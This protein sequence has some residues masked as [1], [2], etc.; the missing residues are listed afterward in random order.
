MEDKQDKK[1]C[2]QCDYENP[3]RYGRADLRCK[4]CGRDITLELVLMYEV[5]NK[6]K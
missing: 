2:N 1:E 4:D 5:E 3:V 6:N